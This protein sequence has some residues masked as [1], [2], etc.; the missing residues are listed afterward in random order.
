MSTQNQGKPEDK[1]EV[2][3]SEELEDELVEQMEARQYGSSLN[4]QSQG[5][6]VQIEA[7]PL[8][9][10]NEV[11]NNVKREKDE[12]IKQIILNVATELINYLDGR[13]VAELKRL[14]NS[15]AI[16][17]LI[18]YIDYAT[19]LMSDRVKKIQMSLSRLNRMLGVSEART[20]TGRRA[21]EEMLYE[22][23]IQSMG[24]GVSSAIEAQSEAQRRRR[25][26]EDILR[27]LTNQGNKSE[28]G[29]Q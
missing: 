21:I 13:S 28:G 22:R 3:P 12:A 10:P 14:K 8:P 5:G 7:V 11:V 9:N 23:L 17:V 29:G 27:E 4:E 1:P 15:E 25:L 24:S 6:G 19:S 26:S 2:K 20:A 16:D 18:S